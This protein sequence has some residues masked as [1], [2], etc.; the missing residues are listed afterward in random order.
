[1]E[2][3][4]TQ[5]GG[6]VDGFPAIYRGGEVAPW[7]R[8]A[9]DP[10]GH[11]RHDAAQVK[12][13]KFS[14]KALLGQEEFKDAQLSAGFEQAAGFLQCRGQVIHVAKAE[15][16]GDAVEGGGGQAGVFGGGTMPLYG[17]IGGG[18]FLGFL[19]GDIQHGSG[20]VAAGD[21]LKSAGFGQGK[22]HV[23]GAAA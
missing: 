15:G 6:Q 20:D 8:I 13:I 4:L 14:G 22:G 19:C 3:G 1:M 10:S 21:G 16:T 9:G 12:E 18:I 23:A 2:A 7:G 11:E 17:G 5:L